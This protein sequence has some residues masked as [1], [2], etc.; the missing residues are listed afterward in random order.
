MTPTAT[1]FGKS[2]APSGA[3]GASNLRSL[4]TLLILVHFICVITVLLSNLG[5]SALQARLVNVFGGYTSALLL[6]PDQTPYYYVT[7][8]QSLHDG[9]DCFFEIDL[10]LDAD[11]P[12][13]Q[14]QILQGLKLPQDES[15]YG[16]ERRR[17]LALGRILS[18]N[19]PSVGE[20]APEQEAVSATIAKGVGQFVLRR[21]GKAKRAVV[22]GVRRQSQPLDLENLG[23]NLPAD[24]P[25][26]PAQRPGRIRCLQS[27]RAAGGHCRR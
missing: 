12:A 14:Q 16:A 4:M 8:Q 9:D 23:G 5:R 11:Q 26:A 13:A 3:W 1:S 6:D 25:T 10:Y 19:V 22:R 27:G 21:S 20:A 17:I 15:R 18:A 7:R 2:A 24:N